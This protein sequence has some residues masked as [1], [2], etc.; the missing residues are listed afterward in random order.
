M[1]YLMD[2][3]INNKATKR[4]AKMGY[5]CPRWIGD[6]RMKDKELATQA[7]AQRRVF[8][9]ADWDFVQ[10]HRSLKESLGYHV[11]VIGRKKDQPALFEARIA[12]LEAKIGACGPGLYMLEAEAPILF[13]RVG[14]GSARKRGRRRREVAKRHRRP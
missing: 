7:V 3:C 14:G 12:D 5:D 11:H 4:L 10:L 1:R 6:P 8:V 13:E 9:S 2:R